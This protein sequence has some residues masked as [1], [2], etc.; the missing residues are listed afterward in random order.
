MRGIVLL[1][2]AAALAASLA[3]DAVAHRVVSSRRWGFPAAGV[4]S[5]AVENESGNI[6]VERWG[7][8]SIDVEASVRVK[9]PAA[10]TARRLRDA[11]SFRV[12]ERRGAVAIRAETPRTRQTAFGFGGGEFTAIR[13]RYRI[14]AP[15]RIVLRLATGNGRIEGPS[16]K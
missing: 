13:I 3:G 5:L 12:E 2:C 4:D 9:A 8:D 1:A 7:R 10:S 16:N 14:R 6:T 11:V 15:E